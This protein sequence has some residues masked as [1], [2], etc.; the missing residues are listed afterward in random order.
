[1]RLLITLGVIP[2]LSVPVL[3]QITFPLSTQIPTSPPGVPLSA[4]PTPQQL[5]LPPHPY[6][7]PGVVY[8]P[9]VWAPTPWLYPSLYRI[10]P[11]F[12]VNPPPAI[13]P[14][15]NL[16]G[17]AS[18]SKKNGTELLAKVRLE[19][20]LTMKVPTVGTWTVDGVILDGEAAERTLT[21][22]PLARNAQHTFT[23]QVRWVADGTTYEVNKTKAVTAG[24]TATIKIYAGT[25]V[26]PNK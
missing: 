14:L 2:L 21:S 13:D 3:A 8:A 6:F 4:P 15:P 12:V 7:Y 19:A 17:G 22:P 9:W 24:D 16:G 26:K 23:V 5:K 11:Q 1:M 25:Q 20:N 18:T 10:Q